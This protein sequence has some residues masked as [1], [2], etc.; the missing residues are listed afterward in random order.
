MSVTEQAINEQKLNQFV[1]FVLR[2]L[3]AG[4]GGPLKRLST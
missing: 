3:A 1:D 2:D 4:S